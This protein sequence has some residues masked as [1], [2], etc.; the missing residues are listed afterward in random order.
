MTCI[1]QSPTDIE[2]V[3]CPTCGGKVEIKV[4]GCD[5]H[6][7]CQ[8]APSLP[9]VRACS[10]C[11]DRREDGQPDVIHADYS[12]GAAKAL[13]LSRL[14]ELTPPGRPSLTVDTIAEFEAAV[15]HIPT[16]PPADEPHGVLY[17]AGGWRFFPSL[18][19]SVKMLRASGC[20]WP[21]AVLYFESRGEFEP[22]MAE[23]L[24]EVERWLPIEQIGWPAPFRPGTPG[25]WQAK[26]LALLVSPFRRTLY[27]DADCYPVRNP[28]TA[29]DA[30]EHAAFWPDIPAGPGIMTAR[31]FGA[32]GMPFWD[33]RNWETGQILVD[34]NQEEQRRALWLATWLAFRP[35]SARWSYGDCGCFQMAW[36]RLAAPFWLH[37]GRPGVNGSPAKWDAVAFVHIGPDN[38]P[39]F[40][41][42]CRDK[43]RLTGHA[44]A[45]ST[46]QTVGD[47][48]GYF[49]HLP[50]EELAQGFY[51]ELLDKIKTPR[52]WVSAGKSATQ[53]R[54]NLVVG[55][56]PVFDLL[57][58]AGWHCLLLS[59][60][61]PEVPEPH[62]R[63]PLID[64][65][66][67]NRANVRLA[68]DWILDRWNV[69]QK[70]AVLCRSG[71]N[72]APAIAAAA[73]QQ[74]GEYKS[75]WAAYE[76][77]SRQRREVGDYG[78]TAL[79]IASMFRS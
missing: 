33:D 45:Y 35:E 60:G 57:A 75:H 12:H 65:I 72:R 4:Y 36:R 48:Q 44:R 41:H 70:V 59:A 23:L 46:P 78:P 3:P 25:G 31:H 9:G 76:F 52:L 11:P 37:Q 47:T 66:G 28:D 63:L 22:R 7:R 40:V 26:P 67:N 21:I 20:Q 49:P 54:E 42:R 14:H 29:L 15:R 43:F 6:G 17:V 13:L 34:G 74:A 69:G 56:F 10:R 73:L 62:L 61:S 32:L 51:R 19:V 16:P 38:E 79:E 71:F 39:L 5:L 8:L 2:R 30:I 58:P 53:I 1:H 64:G 55:G 50:G 77:L 24:P 68:V 18:Y 27:L